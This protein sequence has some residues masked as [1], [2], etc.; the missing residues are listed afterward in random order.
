MSVF[1]HIDFADHEGVYFASDPVSGLKA[2]IAVHSTVRGP[3]AGGTRFWHY[4]AEEDALRDV[5][6]LSKA[7]SYKNAAAEL[8]L[9]GGKAVIIR[10]KG[11]FDRQSLFEAYGRAIERL[12]GSYIT[13]EDVGVS[14]NDM[15]VIRTQTEYVAGLTS[16]KAA[17][18]DPSPVTAE[19]VFRGIK[20]AANHI[21]GSN[22]LSDKTVA[23]QGL[24]HVGY[25]LCEKLHQAG[26]SLR[27][28]DI[29]ETVIRKAMTEFGAVA[30]DVN[31][32]HAETV[33]IF[34]PCALGGALN[35]QSIPDIKAKLIAGAANN[36]FRHESLMED[37]KARNITYLPDFVL[38]AG[39]IINVAAEVSGEYS[40]AWVEKKL[41]G[42]AD[43]IK[44]ILETST[45]KNTSTLDVANQIAEERLKRQAM[46]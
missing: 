4:D 7:M 10:P 6:R 38:N 15:N 20:V 27:V 17:S 32:I 37:L 8:P 31:D 30:V 44:M 22:D 5:L 19:G 11:D 33:D 42:L 3:S 36:Q 9:G 39:G 23:V 41:E 12:N 24:G 35:E 16:G 46:T 40:E 1:S 18:G 2:I 21:W 34:S 45:A 28:A 29:N 25:S 14:P 26:T 13:A 43:T